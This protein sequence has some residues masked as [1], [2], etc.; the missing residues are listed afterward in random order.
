[1]NYF[2]PRGIID[3]DSENSD[4]SADSHHHSGYPKA[5]NSKHE[6]SS[7]N[8]MDTFTSSENSKTEPIDYFSS[9]YASGFDDKIDC[10]SFDSK[11]DHANELDYDENGNEFDDESS[12]ASPSK[13]AYANENDLYHDFKAYGE[14]VDFSAFGGNNFMNDMACNYNEPIQKGI[15]IDESKLAMFYGSFDAQQSMP[16]PSPI[17]LQPIQNFQSTAYRQY[18]QPIY[19]NA[20]QN[21]HIY[22]EATKDNSQM[23]AV[24]RRPQRFTARQMAKKQQ[25]KLVHEVSQAQVNQNLIIYLYAKSFFIAVLCFL[26]PKR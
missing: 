5:D 24:N 11:P 6:I 18:E 19:G 4:I 9:G 13:P 20:G 16:F 26:L 23:Y 14:N 22:G 15:A 17:P 8:E 1:M 21:N 25:H 7:N 2:I 12:Q 10:N 3:S